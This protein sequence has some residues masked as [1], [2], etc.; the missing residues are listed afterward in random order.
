MLNTMMKN[1]NTSF[2]FSIIVLN[3]M[4]LV[5]IPP[6]QSYNLELTDITRMS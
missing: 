6:Y 4:K 5:V 1:E 3:M 2:S